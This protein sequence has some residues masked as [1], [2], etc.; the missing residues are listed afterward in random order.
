VAAPKRGKGPPKRSMQQGG[1]FP[2]QQL[3]QM[4]PP[5][6]MGPPLPS[7]VGAMAPMSSP[8]QSLQAAIGATMKRK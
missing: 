3:R 4:G 1:T 8:A 7:N 6:S 5:K 2:P